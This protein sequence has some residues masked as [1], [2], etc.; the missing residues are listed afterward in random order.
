MQKIKGIEIEKNS[1]GED[2]FIRI[3]FQKFGKQ[4]QPFLEEVGLLEDDFEKEWETALTLDEAKEKSIEKVR[5]W[6][7]K[8]S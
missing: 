7:E 1:Q 8:M 5:S 6:W 2:A 3:D 4:L